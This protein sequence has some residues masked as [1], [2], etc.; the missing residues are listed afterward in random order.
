MVLKSR[1]SLVLSLIFI[2]MLFAQPVFAQEPFSVKVLTEKQS[3]YVGNSANYQIEVMNNLNESVDVQLV[4]TISYSNWFATQE[5][6]TKSIAPNGTDIID[7]KIV[8]D[9]GTS[10]GNLAITVSVCKVR[11]NVCSDTFINMQVIDKSQLK[12]LSFEPE[13]VESP[14]DAGAKFLFRLENLGESNIVSYKFLVEAYD[15]NENVVS[16]RTVDLDKIPSNSLYPRDGLA[17]VL[18]LFD[19]IGT[20][21][22]SAKIIDSTGGA[23]Q[24]E[25]SKITITVPPEVKTETIDKNTVPG[26]LF[27]KTTYSVQNKNSKLNSVEII[28]PVFLSQYIYSFSIEP[29]V[30]EVDGIKSFVWVCDLAISG[31]V[32]DSCEISLTANYWGIYLLIIVLLL[33]AGYIYIMVEKPKVKKAYINKGELHSIHIHVKNNSVKP[34]SDVIVTDIL[35]A[36]L[37][38]VGDYTVK[39]TKINKK[40]NC[41]ELV[42]NLG[43]L[44]SKEERILTYDVKP[45]V[46]V[47]GGIDLP[48][49]EIKAVN[50][51]GKHE[52]VM[53]KSI[54]L[55]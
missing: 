43:T 4:P 9:I 21:D 27:E 23:V 26:I 31:A 39:P 36:V 25:T 30:V 53:S 8:P 16:N 44:K 47:E 7:V 40:H 15:I 17:S 45:V 14:M 10:S 18:L 28:H 22:V 20:Y 2:V 51:R 46:E 54:V 12:I 35:P 13:L 55:S 19:A 1:S 48:A 41:V 11:S 37:K 42:W 33:L 38:I 3:V 49:V 24:T 34:L 6:Y 5:N 50:V 32:G 29:D 52:K